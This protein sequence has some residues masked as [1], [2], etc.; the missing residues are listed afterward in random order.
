MDKIII[1][2][3][4]LECNIGVTDAER[5]EK[6]KIVV[7]VEMFFDLNVAGK[8][9]NINDTI[10]YSCVCDEIRKI[11][12]KEC[13]LLEF[14]AEKIAAIIL[15]KFN[16]EKIIVNVKKEGVPK[17]AKSSAVEIERKK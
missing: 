2:D 10:N 4:E 11:S 9:D 1:E 7:S 3:L 14:L 6:Q 5:A 13:K 16:I 17:C 12:E 8:S 15:M